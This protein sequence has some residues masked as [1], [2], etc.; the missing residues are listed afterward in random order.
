M[1]IINYINTG[2][3][4]NTGDGDSLRTAFTKINRNFDNLVDSFVAAGV[5][6][7][8]GRTG[9]V[10]FTNAD[11]L[12]L[13]GFQPYPNSNPEGYVT[14]STIELRNYASI[15][16][17][18]T[19]FVFVSELASY[20]FASTSYVDLKL[21]EYPTLQ[22]LTDQQYINSINLPDFLT[23][24]VTEAE[25]GESA[26][27]LRTF[28]TDAVFEAVSNSDIVPSQADVFNLGQESYRWGSLFLA[29]AVYIQGI[30]ISVDPFTG[31]LIVDGNDILGSF[32]INETGISKRNQTQYY[33]SN[34]A[35]AG[36][37]AE[38]SAWI[39][40]PGVNDVDTRPLEL[41]STG[42]Q[43]I[44][45]VGGTST[46]N[47][48]NSGIEVIGTI[49]TPIKI[50]GTGQLGNLTDTN[51]SLE[52]L[53]N[54]AF[55]TD[56]TTL[57]LPQQL[58]S[59]ASTSSLAPFLIKASRVS[60]HTSPSD[61]FIDEDIN[62]GATLPGYLALD[63]SGMYL[64]RHVSRGAG[65]PGDT[66][67]QT[68]VGFK[69]PLDRG[70]EGQVLG[71]VSTGTLFDMVDWVTPAGGAG[72]SLTALPSSLIP[73]ADL[74]YD[75]GSTSSQWRSLYVG[76]STIYLGGTA[77]S[78]IGGSIAINGVPISVT[79]GSNLVTVDDTAPS[80][81]PEGKLWFNNLDGRTY[82]SYRGSWVDANP[83]VVP[84]PSTYLDEITIDGSTI[85]MNGSTLAINNAGV[86]LVNGSEV[87]GT[88][89][90][91]YTPTTPADWLGSPT[92]GTITAGLDELASRVSDIE[93]IPAVSLTTST[94]I[95]GTYTVTLATTG[96]INLP[97]SST[98]SARL[99][100]TVDIDILSENSLW[101]FGTDGV[102][103]LP[104]G[105]TRIGNAYGTD[106]I[107][108][109]TGTSVGVLV[110]GQSAAGGVQWLDNIDNIG[111]S[112]TQV[113]AVIV[114]SQLAS[115]TGTVQIVTGVTSS[116]SVGSNIWEFGSTGTLTAPGHILPNTDV[117][118]DLGSP[119]A[120]F[121]SLY[122]SSSTIY[123][124]ENSV[125]V[126][127]VGQLLVNG[128]NAVSSYRKFTGE[129]LVPFTG[130]ESDP[131]GASAVS[132]LGSKLIILDPGI[133]MKQAL[134][135]LKV[136]SIVR[137]DYPTLPS[138]EWTVVGVLEEYADT[139]TTLGPTRVWA[140]KRFEFVIS[141]NTVATGSAVN[142]PE[143]IYLPVMEKSATIANGPY[144]VSISPTGALNVSGD[145]LPDTDLAYNLGSPTKRF[146]DLYLSTSTI[147]IGEN[148]VS[149]SNDGQM[150][151]NGNDAV[152]KLE[153]FGGEGG[154]PR[155]A[156]SIEWNTSTF[157]F[158]IPGRELLTAIYDLKPGNKIRA[159]NTFGF[160]QEF[161][162]AS[163]AREYTR[164]FSNDI[165]MAA[166]DVV[167]TTSTTRYAFSLYLPVK[168]KSATLSNGTWTLAVSTTGTVVFPNG[169]QQSGAAISIAQL[170]TLVAA[171]TDFANFKTRIAAL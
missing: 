31:R 54:Q 119:T 66:N 148:S 7:W 150:L 102:L 164:G 151:V 71:I 78:V 107:V 94:L 161:T 60:L 22:F 85:S 64:G 39:S 77:L 11:L 96:Q 167:E 6:S 117:A 36:T 25:L 15:T 35:T 159:A 18:N 90:S 73:N 144:S 111:S 166:I 65:D 16:Y 103:T 80:A 84:A 12:Q 140:V 19:S 92:V 95:A 37:G 51:H 136:G 121:R 127:D 81:S 145:I 20:N 157:T 105:N 154:S 104:G 114:N 86:L 126:S 72:L 165:Q 160:D 70:F 146:N 133:N 43:G 125:S 99:Q 98:N 21:T 91:I 120:K 141:E 131:D 69:L 24:Y 63:N 170:K 76:T 128:A 49:K 41:V 46:V 29:N 158:N 28:T 109:N 26:T 50:S 162:I 87:T 142:Y 48:S 100:S 27:L 30:G 57:L 47:I 10:D 108:G 89:G 82:V 3:G 118:Y 134:F 93:N 112:G 52:F 130:P 38:S 132:W 32:L 8:N 5:A 129:T 33:L 88:G 171:S 135:D 83:V 139:I 156:G 123:I 152:S 115:S 74:A 14:S 44:T 163:S 42:T 101:T 4:A 75:L 58:L 116:T 62:P 149:V 9:N 45:L 53:P 56:D 138:K 79:G 61:A 147:Y 106:A 40:V 155:D 67:F 17:V 97:P 122:L 137:A 168:D 1:S 34:A 113:A 13:L 169:T 143:F 55:Q 59:T 153:Y 68:F 124:G 110:H 2:S 23:N